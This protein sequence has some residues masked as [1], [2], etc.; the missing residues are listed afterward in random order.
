MDLDVSAEE[1]Y[2]GHLLQQPARR[3]HD[4]REAHGV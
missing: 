2:V 4:R 3:D 1:T